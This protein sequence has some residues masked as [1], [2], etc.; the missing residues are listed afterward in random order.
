MLAEP[1]SA[2]EDRRQFLGGS[3]LGAVLGVHPKRTPL[4]VYE[5]KVG[6]TLPFPGN[7][8]TKRGIRLEQTAAEEWMSEQGK[9]LHRDNRRYRHPDYPFI[10][11]RVDRRIIG[12]DA[13]AEI[14]C[15]SLGAYSKIK[16]TGLHEG[17]IV[18][19]QTYLGLTV[20]ETGVWIIFCADQWEVIQ[21][22]IAFDAAMYASIVERGVRFWRE[23]V[24]PRV[25]PPAVV[26]DEDRVAI[27]RIAGS[28]DRYEV[29]DFKGLH[30]A[31]EMLREARALA[32]EASLL[33]DEA[34]AR[35]RAAAGDKF[36][37][38]VAEDYRL[39]RTMQEG[40]S[41]FDKEALRGA[42]PLDRLK[43][44][45]VLAERDQ[46]RPSADLS[47]ALGEGRCDMD[48]SQFNK[49]G[50]PFEVLRLAG[51]GE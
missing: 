4:Q 29:R 51:G 17:Y 6:I 11:G 41:T 15:P 2:G 23:H 32:A 9:Q 40:R 3:D 19:M 1:V 10:A 27:A 21:F 7:R 30:P 24:I 45:A 22:P 43:V 25:P 20:C 46:A 35:V 12:A 37:V 33:E 14:K 28:V 31:V 44:M 26:A 8:D 48:L 5:E 16:R 47:F 34:K 36:G 50:K 49:Q 13:I 18:Q 38:F 42:R 39:S